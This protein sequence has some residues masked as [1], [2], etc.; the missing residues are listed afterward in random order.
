MPRQFVDLADAATLPTG[1]FQL[2]ARIVRDLVEHDA[3]GV[4]HGPAGTGKTYAVEAALEAMDDI[5]DHRRPRVCLL[6]FPTS[7]TMRLIA[8]QLLH[9]LTGVAA[10]RSQNRF[11]L[12][13]RLIGLLEAP[14]RLIVIDEAQRLNGDCIELLRHLHD[15]PATRFALLYVGGNGCWE[16]LSREPMLRSRI[17]RRLPFKPIPPDQVPDL[18]RGYHPIYAGA[19]D[20]TLRE[21]DAAYG[22]GHLRDWAVF[23]HTAAA[24]C[25]DSG[26]T[27]VDDTVIANAYTLLGG[28]LDG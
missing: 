9:A 8:D 23:T 19:D 10:P 20:A 25:A 4:I 2:T 15:H 5:P 1:H 27:R 28:G 12:T 7:P 16:V 22:H 24:L 14:R 3:T 26:R 6:T 13:T 18:M 21:I 11:A 17:F